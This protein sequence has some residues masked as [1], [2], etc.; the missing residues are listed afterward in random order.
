M[1]ITN[2]CLVDAVGVRRTQRSPSHTNHMLVV[3]PIPSP[4]IT[5][6]FSVGARALAESDCRCSA[7]L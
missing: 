7:H 5:F 3:V 4:S 1:S 6:I 2:Q